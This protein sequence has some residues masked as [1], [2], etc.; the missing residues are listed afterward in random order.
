MARQPRQVH[1]YL[2]RER[3]KG[4]E[5]GIFQR[6]DEPVCWQGICGGLEGEETLEEGARRE[7]QEEAGIVEAGGE[8]IAPLVRLESI[9]YLPDTAFSA[10]AR[11]CWGQ[12]RM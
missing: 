10:K 12:M 11:K 8:R 7:I 3:E 1:I 9:S 5:Y 6:S 4:Y 2:F